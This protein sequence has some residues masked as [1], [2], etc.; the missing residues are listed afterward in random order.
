MADWVDSV[1]RGGKKDLPIWVSRDL[2]WTANL[3]LSV[4]LLYISRFNS[5][6][7]GMIRSP[8]LKGRNLNSLAL[9]RQVDASP[10]F[11]R[12]ERAE[13]TSEGPAQIDP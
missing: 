6:A 13:H 1:M 9:Q 11:P 7:S 5:A 12:P 10:I 3:K 4:P 2:G 8:A